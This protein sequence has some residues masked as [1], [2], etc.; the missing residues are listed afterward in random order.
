[1][2]NDVFDCFIK[3]YPFIFRRKI[4]NATTEYQF[5]LKDLIKAA[6]LEKII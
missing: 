2:A 3:I 6:K 5:E 4:V 1:M